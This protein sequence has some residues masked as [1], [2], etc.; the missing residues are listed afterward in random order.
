MDVVKTEM[1]AVGGEVEVQSIPLQ[2]TTILLRIPLTLAIIDGLLVEV[3]GESYFI[4]IGSVLECK[5][6]IDWKEKIE[7]GTINFR[8]ELITVVDLRRAFS[9]QSAEG[10]TCQMV[11]AGSTSQK[12]GLLVDRIIG[13]YQTVI[14]P[15]SNRFS[16]SDSVTGAAILGN[17]DVALILDV[18]RVVRQYMKD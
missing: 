7:L 1:D 5:D 15:F 9:A 8:N 13:Q 6:D 17:G 10:K 3:G 14:K 12:I 4:D 11:I 18:N 16:R 2:G